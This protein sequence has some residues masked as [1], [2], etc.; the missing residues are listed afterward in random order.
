MAKRSA[1]DILIAKRVA[2]ELRDGDVVNLGV[3]IPTL[4]PDYMPEGKVV[5]L[6]SENGLLGMG[7]TPPPEEVDMEFINA[8]KQPVT[9]MPG[10]SVFN[11]ADSFAMIRGGHIDV[12][13]LGALQVDQTGLIANWLIPGRPILGVGGAMDLVA[14]AKKIIL[15]MTHTTKDG[16]PKLLKQLTFPKTG[17]RKADMVIT[18]KAVFRFENDRMILL[19]IQPDLTVDELRAMTE[20]EFDVSAELKPYMVQQEQQTLA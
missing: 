14:G 4:V 15:A 11:S 16:K 2:L 5:Y 10:A 12:C 1:D 6:Q 9:A 19:E 13:V 7:P 8:S 20:A 18:E 17:I 3:G